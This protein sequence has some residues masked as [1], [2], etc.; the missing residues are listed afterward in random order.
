MTNV[1]DA[2]TKRGK[3]LHKTTD[4]VQCFCWFL[5]AEVE[6]EEDGKRQAWR[7]KTQNLRTCHR[8]DLKL[9]AMAEQ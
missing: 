2:L 9:E 1:R 3:A 4:N 5:V 8:C 7:N 6:P